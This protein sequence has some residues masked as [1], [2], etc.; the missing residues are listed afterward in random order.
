MNRPFKL[1]N[2][3]E[4]AYMLRKVQEELQRDSMAEKFKSTEGRRIKVY[5][6]KAEAVDDVELLSKGTE[7]LH[8]FGAVDSD[9]S[10]VGERS[11]VKECFL[12]RTL[13]QTEN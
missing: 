5:K 3:T 10:T 9:G 2:S 8:K 1:A 4:T 13:G 7:Q 12:H 6:L 11:F